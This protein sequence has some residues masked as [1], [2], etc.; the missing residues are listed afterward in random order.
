MFSRIQERQN[1]T[2][3]REKGGLP[4]GPEAPSQ[5][6]RR[7]E[8]P[9]TAETGRTHPGRRQR[10][11]AREGTYSGTATRADSQAARY[12]SPA[13]H[14]SLSL[15]GESLHGRKV[16]QVLEEVGEVLQEHTQAS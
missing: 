8:A 7:S 5:R 10:D 4:K 2:A 14:S 1:T 9:T 13:P 11:F 15:L 12:R 16:T 6:V 3:A